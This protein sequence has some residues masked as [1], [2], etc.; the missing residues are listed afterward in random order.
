MRLLLHFQPMDA[1]PAVSDRP[2]L[3]WNR[4]VSTLM[5]ELVFAAR[6]GGHEFDLLTCSRVAELARRVRERSPDAVLTNMRPVDAS[7]W[8]KLRLL[9]ATRPWVTLPTGLFDDGSHRI[10]LHEGLAME[11]LIGHLVGCGCRR[12]GF[13]SFGPSGARGAAWR[14][15][16]K[17]RALPID[18]ENQFL[19]ERRGES[20]G[21]LRPALR[22]F[23]KARCAPDGDAPLQA[24]MAFNDTIARETVRAAQAVGLRVPEDLAVTG[25]DGLENPDAKPSLTTVQVDLAETARQ[26]LFL[27]EKLARGASIL[28]GETRLVAGRLRPGDSTRRLRPERPLGE[29]LGHLLGENLATLDPARECA[30][31]ME[32]SR[33]YFLKRFA[34]ETGHRFHATL[35]ERRM[36]R[37]ADLFTEGRT[38]EEVAEACGYRSARSFFRHV[39]EH[40]RDTPGGLRARL[41]PS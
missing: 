32:W 18:S 5:A 11:R 41:R 31:A 15:A 40:F 29:R 14:Q 28:R 12:I 9:R 21:A 23:L 3:P 26:A 38:A 17:E 7:D 6:R 35:L 37:A 19:V 2:W 22:A 34:L 1:P 36:A 20:W 39:S 13:V 16:M 8:Q 27:A 24:L 30:R 10:A 33:A 4:F 25:V